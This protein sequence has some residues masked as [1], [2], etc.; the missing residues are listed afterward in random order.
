MHIRPFKYSFHILPLL[1]WATRRKHTCIS[2]T[3]ARFP[4]IRHILVYYVY[5]HKRISKVAALFADFACT[6]I[7]S[8]CCTSWDCIIH[9]DVNVGEN[10]FYHLT[11]YL[12][13]EPIGY[14]LGSLDFIQRKCKYIRIM[15]GM[16]T[17]YNAKQ[18]IAI[19]VNAK[20]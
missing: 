7:H 12:C 6:Y 2:N 14:R 18:L 19:W 3:K 20:C 8:F 5:I 15:R 13:V 16:H 11:I 1:R 9:T 10:S 17:S 4:R